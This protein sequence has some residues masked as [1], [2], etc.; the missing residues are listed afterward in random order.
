MILNDEVDFAI[1]T[2]SLRESRMK[3]VDFLVT[4]SHISRGYIYV[5][6][7]KETFDWKV[8]GQPFWQ[9]TWLGVVLFCAIIPILIGIILWRCE[10]LKPLEIQNTD[11][12]TTNI[13]SRFENYFSAGNYQTE[14]PMRL[15]DCYS[16]MYRSLLMLGTNEVAGTLRKQIVFFTIFVTGMFIYLIW[17][18]MLISYFT[19]P[20]RLFPFN[21]WEEFLTKTDNKVRQF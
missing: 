17:E 12:I 13:V 3:V 1:S 6:N 5:Q 19:V 8:Y 4:S 2:F 9:Q 14:K 20:T 21:S 15:G 11:Y 7:P 10:L 18:A 16:L